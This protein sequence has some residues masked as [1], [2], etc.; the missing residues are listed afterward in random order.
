[1][2]FFMRTSMV[3]IAAALI[4]ASCRYEPQDI[5]VDAQKLTEVQFEKY[6]LDNGLDVV[7]HVD[8][9]DPIVAI[10]L[11]VHVGSSRELPGRTGFAHLFEHLLFLDSENLGFGGLDSM[12]T[13]IGGQ[14]T[15]GFTTRDMT[16]YFQAV[17]K[18]ALEKIIWAEA[19]KIGYFINTVTATVLDKEKQVVKNE[20]RLRVD[21]RPYGHRWYMVG[22]ALYAD[23]HPYNWQVIGSLEDLDAAKLEDVKNFYNKWYG[24][25]NVTVTLTGDFDVAKAKAWIEK[26]FGEIPRGPDIA[27]I[28]P[29][30]S[31]ITETKS[32]YYE[33]NFATLAEYG[34]VWPTVPQYHK[35][36][37]A[38]NILSQ[39]LGRGKRAAF[40][41]VM[42]D[43]EKLT[44]SISTFTNN[45]EIAG[46]FYI[47]MNAKE[48][49]D[50][51]G[52]TGGVAKSFARFEENGVSQAD[53]DVIKTAQEVAFYANLQGALNKA[54][55][56]GE[57]NMFTGDP[58]FINQDIKNIQAV[59]TEDVM[60]VYETYIKNKSHI[61]T[62][63]VPKGKPELAL[64]GAKLAA[65]VEEKIVQGAEKNVAETE[66][67]R[68]WPRTASSFDRT[69][70]PTF[71]GAY[72]LPS[73]D[74]WKDEL[75][76]G[77]KL[78][79]IEN[80]ETPLVYFSL[81]LDAGRARGSAGKPAVAA[82][83]ADMLE[84][85]T[86][87]L[88]TAEFEDA[89]NALGA[90]LRI[91]SGQTT[92]VI[93][94]NTL[95][96]NFDATIAL[97]MDMLLNPRWD[98]EEFEFLVSEAVD[99]IT[100]N[101]GN[102]SSISTRLWPQILYPDT[103]M[104]HYTSSGP[105]DK[106]TT[107]TIDD[108]KAF[109]AKNY[110]PGGA[111]FRVAGNIS[112]VQ[113][114][115]ALQG[116]ESAWTTETPPAVNLPKANIPKTS[117]VYFY[118]V[119]GAKQSVLRFGYPT[120]TALDTDYPKAN[121]INYL[122][123]NIYTSTLN[124]E[125]RVNKGYTYGIRSGFSVSK[126]RGTFTVRSSVRANVTLE[127]TQLIRDILANYGP[128]FTEDDLTTM[129]S[130]LIKGQALR[131]ETLSAKLGMLD[132]IVAYGYPDDYMSKNAEMVKAMDLA[133]FKRVAD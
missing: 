45:S 126:D 30:A 41:E 6:T 46:E 78:I 74:I 32:L 86:T 83:T 129:K 14:G 64:E 59:T 76:N 73:P 43:E 54:I 12:N 15:N 118:D 91:G 37:Y 77:L 98:E 1:M 57:Y 58:S 131:T 119:P 48:D 55:Q 70:E 31:G 88:T 87:S 67:K 110:A 93:N 106:L 109:H 27:P 62:S 75:E 3:V 52:L 130:A 33:D 100:A 97:V 13:R 120:L 96:R 122:L 24:P 17:P 34:M 63:I 102:P 56:L 38:L 116:L 99:T 44:T 107:V 68:D 60:R 40:N 132:G 69:I 22:K 5:S 108:L 18:D 8:R 128:D 26:Y 61:R 79:G 9:S 21:N 124:T 84:K 11:A 10:N 90:S 112:K 103:H 127:A 25:N 72:S 66:D 23:D 125:L 53:L 121:A 123:G 105:K 51:D 101:A 82:L 50:I 49:A 29:R 20:K 39:T 95:A 42:I 85:G 7:L 28:T 36:A 115:V 92:T 113:V 65:I 80:D 94:G 104:F 89:L 19:D 16:Q 133:E 81:S 35:D 47:L 2:K 117:K 4:L 114:V 71:G 111:S